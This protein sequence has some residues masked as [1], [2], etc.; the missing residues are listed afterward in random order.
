MRYNPH[1]HDE[2][3][4]EKLRDYFEEHNI[5]YLHYFTSIE[6]IQ[7]I[8]ELGILSR[9]QVNKKNLDSI[10]I[11]SGWIQNIRTKKIPGTNIKIQ[12]CVPLY[13][14][15][16]T[17][18]Q[19]VCTRGRNKKINQDQL[20]F[21]DIDPVTILSR[22]GIYFTNGNAAAQYTKFYNTDNFSNNINDL[23]NIDWQVIHSG[24]KSDI[25]YDTNKHRR[26][27]E[28]LIPFQIPTE[29]FSKI[30]VF[31]NKIKKQLEDI[32]SEYRNIRITVRRDYYY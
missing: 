25:S 17:P 22:K 11:S 10:D 9:N 16:H 13:F 4:K 12:D 19:H 15:T 30:V 7:S 14:A 8:M 21:I 31:G 27:A 18:M 6:N 5:D 28:V 32:L 1:Y 29:D 23:D 26:A 24:R 2:S 20:V 3:I